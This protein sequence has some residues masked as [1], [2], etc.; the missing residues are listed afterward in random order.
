MTHLLQQD[1]FPGMYLR[2]PYYSLHRFSSRAFSGYYRRGKGTSHYVVTQSP[3]SLLNDMSYF[4]F[5]VATFSSHHS[6]ARRFP[7]T[8]LLAI[9][10]HQRDRKAFASVPRTYAPPTKVSLVMPETNT[11]PFELLTAHASISLFAA[12]ASTGKCPFSM[13]LPQLMQ[14]LTLVTSQQLVDQRPTNG[15]EGSVEVTAMGWAGRCLSAWQAACWTA[16]RN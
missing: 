4:F 5:R 9:R 8:S 11:S 7:A 13:T 12:Y 10:M 1:N 3:L 6:Y 16:H 15:D 14:H 2:A